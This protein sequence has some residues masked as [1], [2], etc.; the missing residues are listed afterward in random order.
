ML[1]RISLNDEDFKQQLEKK[2]T[3]SVDLPLSNKACSMIVSESLHAEKM[4]DFVP[5]SCDCK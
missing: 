1:Q 5:G 2:G 3:K 4:T